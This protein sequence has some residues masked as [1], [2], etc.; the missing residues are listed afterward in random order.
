[1]N[2]MT[3]EYPESWL[4]AMGLNEG[5]FAEEARMAAAMKLFERGRL[6]S[7]QAAQFAGISR[8]EFLLNCRRWGVD[9]VSWDDSDLAAEFANDLPQ[10]G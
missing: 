4:A 3:L 10:K 7:G 1:M 2:E 9:S 8:V 6:S 5:D